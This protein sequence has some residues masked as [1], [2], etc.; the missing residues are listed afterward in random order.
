MK[1]SPKKSTHEQ[2]QQ[3]PEKNNEEGKDFAHYPPAP[4]EQVKP[5]AH[6]EKKH[7]ARQSSGGMRLVPGWKG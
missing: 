5:P 6:K 7:D 4:A 3:E 1:K 2:H